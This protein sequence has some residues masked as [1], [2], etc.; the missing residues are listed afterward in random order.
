MGRGQNHTAE[1]SDRRDYLAVDKTVFYSFKEI[2]LALKEIK[3]F[4]VSFI[5]TFR[6]GYSF[7]SCFI[8]FCNI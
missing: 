6:Y 4:I 2:K 3:S 5:L 8:H 7:V 1:E